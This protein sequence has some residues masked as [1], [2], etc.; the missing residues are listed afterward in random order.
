MSVDVGTAEGHLDLDISGFLNS[1][2][3]AK[4]EASKALNNVEQAA[5]KQLT[6]LGKSMS[7]IGDKMTLGITTPLVGVATA[8]LKVASDFEYAMSQVQAI[9]GATGDDFEALRDQAIQLGADTSFSST[10]VADAMT[11]CKLIGRGV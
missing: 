10:E 9:S 7:K 5:G 3:T 1:L 11:E 6:G 8:G 4:D 2:K